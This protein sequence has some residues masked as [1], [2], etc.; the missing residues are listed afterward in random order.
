MSNPTNTPNPS[1]PRNT[2]RKFPWSG[3]SVKP[4]KQSKPLDPLKHSEQIFVGREGVSN[5]TYTTNLSIPRNTISKFPSRGGGVK[6]YKHSKPFNPSEHCEQ[7]SFEEWGVL[8]PT[9]TRKPSIPQCTLSKFLWRGGSVK[10]Y[11]H[12]KPFNPSKHSEQISLKG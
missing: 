7:K 10:P 3:G 8:N 12:Y 5:P 2:M 11:K 4:Y 9:H 6:P 1:I